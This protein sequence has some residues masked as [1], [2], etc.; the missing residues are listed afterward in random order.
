MSTKCGAV[1]PIHLN[2][3]PNFGESKSS[4]R[5]C[6]VGAKQKLRKPIE[7]V[8]YFFW[9]SPNQMLPT[10]VRCC[11]CSS[12]SVSS[13]C[14]L[15]CL[16]QKKRTGGGGVDCSLQLRN[17]AQKEH[18]YKRSTLPLRSCDITTQVFLPLF[19]P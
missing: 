4:E 18:G 12:S 11:S 3:G 5:I 17:V 2:S 1:V 13:F 10:S 6:G 14:S 9:P 19:S 8:F 7:G 16:R 15:L